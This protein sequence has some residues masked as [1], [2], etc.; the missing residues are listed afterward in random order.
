MCR[1]KLS[2]FN[3]SQINQRTK[4]LSKEQQKTTKIILAKRQILNG[5][6][7]AGNAVQ[8]FQN[9]TILFHGLHHERYGASVSRKVAKAKKGSQNPAERSKRHCT[10]I[11][12][13]LYF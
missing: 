6:I 3:S 11:R 7:T 8:S 9:A 1:A 10:R 13:N 5:G 2:L 12:K 4:R